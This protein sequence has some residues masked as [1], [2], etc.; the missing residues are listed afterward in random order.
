[1]R[2]VPRSARDFG[3]R[4][5]RRA[6]ASTFGRVEMIW[7]ETFPRACEHLTT[8]KRPRVSGDPAPWAT[9]FRPLQR[10]PSPVEPALS[11]VEG[12]DTAPPDFPEWN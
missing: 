7:L 6:I 4:L 12:D 10:A 5:R 2:E 9:F 11:V 8:R 1:M 3:A